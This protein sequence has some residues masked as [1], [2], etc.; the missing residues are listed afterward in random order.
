MVNVL[1]NMWAMTSKTSI[2]LQKHFIQVSASLK[3]QP[4]ATGVPAQI[5]FLWSS[6]NRVN[7]LSHENK[8]TDKQG[9]YDWRAEKNWTGT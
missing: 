7:L 9:Q 4:Q 6:R 8:P 2:H 1:C 3:S 5:V